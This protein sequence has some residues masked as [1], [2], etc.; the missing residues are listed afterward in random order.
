MSEILLGYILVYG[1]NKNRLHHA[2][3]MPYAFDDNADD[4][5]KFFYK[6]IVAKKLS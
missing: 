3:L 2:I 6:N 1:K 4:D 5:A